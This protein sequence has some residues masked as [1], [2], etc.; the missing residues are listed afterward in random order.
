MLKSLPNILT[1]TRLGLSGILLLMILY[2]PRAGNPAAYLYSTFILFVITGLTDIVD[3]HI[4]R[5]FNATSKFG[6]IIDPLADKVLVCG[7]FICFA[8]IGQ[9]TLFGL[10]AVPLAIIHWSVAAILVAREAYV[11]ILRQIAEARGINF[12]ATKS[13]KFKMLTQTFAIGTV[14]IKMALVPTATWGYWFTSVVFVVMIAA[15]V[16]SGVLATRRSRWQQAKAATHVHEP[17]AT[18]V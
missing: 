17:S 9:P 4:A 12:A 8:I 11:T 2:Y 10:S 6:R 3:G 1:L 7:A 13:G 5:R 16:V 18:S 15:T 14:L